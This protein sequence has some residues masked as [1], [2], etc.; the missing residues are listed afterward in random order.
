MSKCRDVIQFFIL[1]ICPYLFEITG[2][3]SIESE[4]YLVQIISN[5]FKLYGAKKK[6]QYTKQAKWL[7]NQIKESSSKTQT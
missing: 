1:Y 6:S 5:Q 3:C 7:Q 4:N 2:T